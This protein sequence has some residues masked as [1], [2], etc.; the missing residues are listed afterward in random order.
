MR[1]TPARQTNSNGRRS[2]ICCSGRSPTC[3]TAICRTRRSSARCAACC[4]CSRATPPIADPRHPG[5]A[6][7][8]AYGFAVPDENALLV[9]KLRGGIGALTS[10]LCEVFTSNGGELR[11]R[12]KVEEIQVADGRVSG[13]RFED[14]SVVTAPVVISAIAPDLTLNQLVAP[15]ARPRRCPRAVLAHRPPRQLP[16][17]ALRA[18][19][20]PGVRGALRTAQRPGHAVQY[21][22]LLH[23]RGI[24]AA[25]GGLQARD[26]ARRPG[27]R[28]ADPVGQRPRPRT[29]GQACGV[30]V[31]TVVPG[32]GI[33][34]RAM[35]T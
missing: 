7:A 24:A 32:R 27:H 4:R 29:A 31:L 30:G 35:A 14:G 11:L 28:A 13:V 19:R 12:T 21:R 15:S 8:L 16:A 22:N 34:S 9:K 17:D 25:V 10:H 1:C 23:P 5:T 20:H 33:S 18:R 6:A 26:R 2:R 3:S